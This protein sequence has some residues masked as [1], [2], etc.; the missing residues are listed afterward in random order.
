MPHLSNERRPVNLERR[1][2]IPAKLGLA[3]PEPPEEVRCGWVVDGPGIGEWGTGYFV[4]RET[5]VILSSHVSMCYVYYAPACRGF[6]SSYTSFLSSWQVLQGLC[7]EN[8][9]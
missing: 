1:G 3:S 4:G 2:S 6:L 8:H 9:V 7:L 5:S